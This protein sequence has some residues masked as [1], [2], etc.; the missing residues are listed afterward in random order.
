MLSKNKKVIFTADDFG[1]SHPFN[2]GIFKGLKTGFLTSACVLPNLEGYMEAVSLKS[3]LEKINFGIHLNLIEG[4]SITTSSYLTDING[5]FNNGYISILR[6]SYDKNFLKAVENEFRSQIE[7]VLSDFNVDHINSHVHIHSIPN[8][9]KLTCKLAEEYNIP[10]IRTQF[11]K[12]YFTKPV[13]PINFI[14]LALL[15]YLTPKN[16][17]ELK[18]MLTNDYLIGIT[19][20]GNMDKNTILDGLKKINK[21]VVE[22]L[23][24]PAYYENN[25]LKPNNYNEFLLTQD[26]NLIE[27]IKSMGFD[28]CNYSLDRALDRV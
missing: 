15:N 21:G 26:E 18:N 17:K 25:P 7:R 6:K 11:E 3:D 1:H 28:I 2:M 27:E 9:F 8:I 23:I 13:K 5:N 12:P 10:Y 22:I 4:K 19:Y 14:K 16:K 24:H 20:T